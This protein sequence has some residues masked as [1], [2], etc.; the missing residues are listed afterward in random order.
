MH[1]CLQFRPQRYPG[2]NAIGL[3]IISE[4]VQFGWPFNWQ[5]VPQHA[6]ILVMNVTSCVIFAL[7]AKWAFLHDDWRLVA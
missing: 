3:G 6:N 2:L 5:P 4:I 7:I 1:T